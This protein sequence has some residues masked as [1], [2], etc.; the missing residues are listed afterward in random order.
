MS[1]SKMEINNGMYAWTHTEDE[2]DD[3]GKNTIEWIRL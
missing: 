1:L 3:K 2:S